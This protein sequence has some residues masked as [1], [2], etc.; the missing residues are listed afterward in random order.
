ME[1]LVAPEKRGQ[2]KGSALIKELLDHEEILGFIIQ[3]SEAVIYP[4]NTASQK[5][6]ENAGFTHHHNHTDGDGSSMHY[7][8]ARSSSGTTN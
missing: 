2:G 7:V 4:G 8:Y 5:A 1:V 3:E 6:F